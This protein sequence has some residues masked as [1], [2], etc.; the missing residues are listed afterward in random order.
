MGVSDRF[1]EAFECVSRRLSTRGFKGFYGASVE[2]KN[3][4]QGPQGRFLMGFRSL[5]ISESFSA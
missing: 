2:S 1:S 4:L 5:G 3:S